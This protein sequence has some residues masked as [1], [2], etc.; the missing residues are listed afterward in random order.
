MS[1]LSANEESGAPVSLRRALPAELRLIRSSWFESYRKGGRCPEV[2]Y[3]IFRP[4]QDAVIA[5]LLET[6]A[7]WVLTPQ[8][9]P[10]EV[11]TWLVYTPGV[12]HYV[13]TKQAYRKLGFA[14]QMLKA[15][16]PFTQYTHETTFGR[17]LLSR[18]GASYN[19]YLLNAAQPPQGAFTWQR[20]PASKSSPSSSSRESTSPASPPR[21][22]S[23]PEA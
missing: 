20:S 3:D 21:P 1:D 13:Y 6:A 7:I 8:S 14:M 17:R 12:V 4:H 2:R 9:V 10:E 23:P 16:G 19:P 15:F 18:V 11:C 5:A 22:S